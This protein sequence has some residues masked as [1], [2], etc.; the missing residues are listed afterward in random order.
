M[1]G[2]NL[3]WHHAFFTGRQ[4][5]LGSKKQ[6]PMCFNLTICVVIPLIARGNLTQ[7]LYSKNG[8]ITGSQSPVFRGSC[9]FRLGLIQRLVTPPGYGFFCWD[10]W[11]APL[12]CI[13]FVT[14]LTPFMVVSMTEEIPDFLSSPRKSKEEIISCG[15]S[16]WKSSFMFDRHYLLLPRS[17]IHNYLQYFSWHYITTLETKGRILEMCVHDICIPTTYVHSKKTVIPEE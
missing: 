16:G 13:R 3:P 17:S 12:L 4:V 14:G 5:D 7:I 1:K 6:E 15:F 9:A 11:N 10:F 2:Y 8:N